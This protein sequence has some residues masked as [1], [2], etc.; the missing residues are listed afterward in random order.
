MVLQEVYS[1]FLSCD[2]GFAENYAEC[3][4][5]R[6]WSSPLTAIK[7]ASIELVSSLLDQM[8]KM[9]QN[10]K[11]MANVGIERKTFALLARRSNQLS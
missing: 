1:Q 2:S 8:E 10:V 6:L 5:K 9:L 4:V 11:N 7:I 3:N